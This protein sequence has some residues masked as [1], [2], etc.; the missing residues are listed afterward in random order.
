MATMEPRRPAAQNVAHPQWWLWP[1]ALVV[2]IVVALIVTNPN[3][4]AQL[5]PVAGIALAIV[6]VAAGMYLR[7]R[8]VVR[9]AQQRRLRR[10]RRLGLR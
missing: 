2:V 3:I 4:L 8:G 1:V 6:A 10:E 7:V 5:G 9:R